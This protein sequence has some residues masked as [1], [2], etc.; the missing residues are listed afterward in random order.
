MFPYCSRQIKPLPKRIPRDVS[1]HVAQFVMPLE[2]PLYVRGCEF[3]FGQEKVMLLIFAYGEEAAFD[4]LRNFR[5]LFK[6]NS[7]LS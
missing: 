3:A 5:A 1:Q 4:M 2:S 7:R 6:F